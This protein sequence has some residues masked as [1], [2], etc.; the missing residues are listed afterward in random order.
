MLFIRSH[1]VTH[2][3]SIGKKQKGSVLITLIIVMTITAVLGAGMVYFTSSSSLSELFSN[4]EAR[5]YYVAEGG[6]RYAFSL[7]KDNPTYFDSYTQGNPY[8]QTFTLQDNGGQFTLVAYQHPTVANN[9]VIRSTGIVNSG[10]WTQTRRLVSWNMSKSSFSGN[11]PNEIDLPSLANLPKKDVAGE[12]DTVNIDGNEALKITDTTSG[13][14]SETYVAIPA[15]TS[16]PLYTAWDAAGGFLNYDSQVKVAIGIWSNLFDSFIYRPQNYCIGITTQHIKTSSAN[17][18]DFYGLS[19]IRTH[20]TGGNGRDNIPDTM[21]PAGVANDSP[22]IMLWIRN[23]NQGNGA[24]YWLAYQNLSTNDYI[25]SN[26]L[27]WPSINPWSTIYLRLVE[28]ASL[29]LAVTDAPLINI[30]STIAGGTG[31][32]KVVKKIQDDDGNVVLLL[33][34]IAGTFSFPASVN[35]YSTNAAWGYRVKD[36]YIWAFYGDT[37]AH[38]TDHTSPLDNYR[39]ANPRSGT[40]AWAVSDVTIWPVAKDNFRLVQWNTSL[41]TSSNGDPSIKLMGKGN[42]LNAI[43]RTNKIITASNYS[44]VTEFPA[45]LGLVCLGDACD[46]EFD[47]GWSTGYF[48]DLAFLAGGGGSGNPSGLQY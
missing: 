20:N 40:L 12:L 4:Q 5:A 37:A 10:L 38:G 6:G 28:A 13:N 33:N 18:H 48:D 15:G 39:L 47:L 14:I 30:G 23:G 35:G 19:I 3:K 2:M 45:M 1:E 43:I 42:E 7:L 25:I 8:N 34:N 31:T 11:T 16:N 24:D 44:P 41:N 22:M 21:I 27:S 46:G 17:Q 29:K 36:N 26:Y 9:V 32:G